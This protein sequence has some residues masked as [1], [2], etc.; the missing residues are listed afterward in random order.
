LDKGKIR[1]IVKRLKQAFESRNI[2]IDRLI[3]FGSQV[4]GQPHSDSDLDI[5]VISDAFSGKGIFERA[6]ITGQVHWE[7]V[8]I[9]KVPLDLIPMTI[10]EYDSGNSL[11]AEFAKQDHHL[12]GFYYTIERG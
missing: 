1:R 3:V 11:I 4:F 10:K 7:I 8:Q 6:K 12:A 2:K 5:I 9:F